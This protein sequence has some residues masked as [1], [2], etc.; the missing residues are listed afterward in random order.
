MRTIRLSKEERKT[1]T[2][3]QRIMLEE[4]NDTNTLFDDFEMTVRLTAEDFFNKWS[5]KKVSE[6]YSW[7]KQ[8]ID[9][10]FEAYVEV[11][12]C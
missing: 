7:R 1:L 5:K 4:M 11:E 9:D 12:A 2:L 8:L 6:L 3:E 10:Y